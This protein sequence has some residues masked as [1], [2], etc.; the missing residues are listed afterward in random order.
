ML[1]DGCYGC[2][3]GW[4]CCSLTRSSSIGRRSSCPSD[5]PPATSAAYEPITE[6][7][8]EDAT[9]SLHTR[10]QLSPVITRRKPMLDKRRRPPQPLSVTGLHGDSS[11]APWCA[12]FPMSVRSLRIR[13]CCWW[14][15][16]SDD[17][18]ARFR[19]CMQ[20]GARRA[21][22]GTRTHAR[23]TRFKD[24]HVRFRIVAMHE[25]FELFIFSLM[26]VGRI[27]LI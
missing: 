17:H 12:N 2:S 22:N 14:V 24:R 1:T 16:D 10:F 7:I 13:R 27:I 21:E 20:I 19:I 18:P 25:L 6:P 15:S 5:E 11:A 3:Y 8:T 26:I 9:S 4:I 23:E